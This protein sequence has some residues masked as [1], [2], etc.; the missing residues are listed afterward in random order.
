MPDGDCARPIDDLRPLIEP[1]RLGD[2]EAQQ[3][4][5]ERCREPL[6]MRIRW[7]MGEEARR[8]AESGDFLQATFARALQAL[9]R[10][11]ERTPDSL[12]RWLTTIARNQIRN[13]VRR[14]REEALSCLSSAIGVAPPAGD[15]GELSVHSALTLL[16]AFSQIGEE[17]RRL[18]ELREFEGKD[19]AEIGAILGCSDRHAHRL[20]AQ[21][22]LRLS[23]AFRRGV[24]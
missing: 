11:E 20:H 22:L 1:A 13:D 2:R 10:F 21:A 18:I 3:A 23:R 14:R 7:M 12:L 6:L 16:D 9:P 17:E 19:F 24:D 4:L 15:D 5:F 8:V